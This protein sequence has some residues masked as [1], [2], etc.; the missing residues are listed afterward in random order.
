M[1]ANGL[2][3]EVVNIGRANERTIE[4]LARITLE[5]CETD[6]EIVYESLPEDDPQ[7]RCPDTTRATELLDWEATIPLRDGLGRTVDYIASALDISTS[8]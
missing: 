2:Q 6:S 1:D 3:G 5:V 8:R 7:R 4:E